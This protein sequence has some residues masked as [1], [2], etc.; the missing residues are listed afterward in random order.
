LLEIRT[1]QLHLQLLFKPLFHITSLNYFSTHD[2]NF[3]ETL[4]FTGISLIS[5]LR[6]HTH[7]HTSHHFSIRAR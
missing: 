1:V 7:T 6:A 5:V 3:G 4:H 2:R